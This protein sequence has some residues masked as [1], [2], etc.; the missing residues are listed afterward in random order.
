M[1]SG[2]YVSVSKYK[3][4]GMLIVVKFVAGRGFEPLIP[5]KT[6]HTNLHKV[7]VPRVLAEVLF[8][9]RS[10]VETFSVSQLLE[11]VQPASN[12][13]VAIRVEDVEV[14]RRPAVASGVKVLFFDDGVEVDV[15]DARTVVRVGI[16]EHVP[17]ILRIVRSFGVPVT[18][19]VLPRRGNL[20]A[21]LGGK[22]PPNLAMPS[23]RA[24]S[25][26]SLTRAR[27]AESVFGMRIDTEYF[28]RSE[29]SIARGSHTLA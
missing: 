18:E 14:N 17:S 28:A 3:R 21:K 15:H 26:A 13:F 10:P 12:A 2:L 6:Q 19:G 4:L 11:V 16:D 23:L 8:C 9:R 22:I 27:V 7:V 29:P 1:S 24:V 25:M 20:A 5:N